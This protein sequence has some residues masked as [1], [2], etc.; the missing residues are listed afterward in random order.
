MRDL[1]GGELAR[2]C[3][4]KVAASPP[5]LLIMDEITNNIDLETKNH[6]ANVLRNYKWQFIIISH[7]EEFLSEIG[8]QLRYDVSEFK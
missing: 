8:V 7:D 1:S 3:M 4:A 5:A 6:I 2:L